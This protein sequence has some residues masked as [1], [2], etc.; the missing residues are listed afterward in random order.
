M[1]VSAMREK[2]SREGNRILQEVGEFVVFKGSRQ[3]RLYVEYGL[4]EGMSHLAISVKG[5]GISRAAVPGVLEEL[6]AQCGWSRVTMGSAAGDEIK[7]IRDG[8]KDCVGAVRATGRTLAFLL[9]EIAA[10]DKFEQRTQSDVF[11]QYL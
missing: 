8:K 10:I 1:M 11:W 9:R 5:I 2:S 4:E 7:L 6:G 3:G